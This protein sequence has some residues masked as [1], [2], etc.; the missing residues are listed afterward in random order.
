M[1]RK[2]L[3]T[4]RGFVG[5]GLKATVRYCALHTPALG[6]WHV[7]EFEVS[8]GHEVIESGSYPYGDR[9]IIADDVFDQLEY[10]YE[11]NFSYAGGDDGPSDADPGL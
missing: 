6:T 8:D 1:T 2:V 4:R 3:S 11:N 7:Y 5:S 10:K 9:F